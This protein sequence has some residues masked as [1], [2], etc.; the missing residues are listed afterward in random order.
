MPTA[1]SL[2]TL[3]SYH[4]YQ[5]LRLGVLVA[6]DLDDIRGG[7]LSHEDVVALVEH[8]EMTINEARMHYGLEPLPEDD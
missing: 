3:N 7:H 2:T 8:E 1:D 6:D 4:L 5:M